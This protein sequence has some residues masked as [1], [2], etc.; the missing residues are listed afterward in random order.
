MFTD[1]ET[2]EPTAISGRLIGRHIGRHMLLGNGDW[3]PFKYG[4]KQGMFVHYSVKI[5]CHAPFFGNKCATVS[6][7]N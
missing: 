7:I 4:L 2:L 3:R 1:T 6:I 5:T